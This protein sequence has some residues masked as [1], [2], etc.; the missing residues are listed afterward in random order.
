M[1]PVRERA[2]PVLDAALER[3]E[4]D[5]EDEQHDTHRHRP[6]CYIIC[7]RIRVSPDGKGKSTRPGRARD[8]METHISGADSS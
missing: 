4:E 7:A 6:Y 1:H 2:Q 8:L 3:Q 5:D